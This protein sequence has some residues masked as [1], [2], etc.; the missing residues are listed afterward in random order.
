MNRRGPTFRPHA[1][2]AFAMSIFYNILGQIANLDRKPPV[3]LFFVF[4]NAAIFFLPYI[5]LLIVIPRE[6]EYI[7]DALVRLTAVHKACLIPA[8][9]VFQR[10]I[11]RIF[12]S[13]LVHGGSLHLVYNLSSFLYKGV[14]LEIELGSTQ[15]FIIIVY[16]MFSSSALYILMAVIADVMN[17]DTSIMNNCCVGFSGV[18]F[19]LKVLVNSDDIYARHT[20]DIFGF[21]MPKRTVW[22][23]LILA[24]LAGPQVSFLGHL[25]GILA[26]IIYLYIAR[27]AGFVTQT[28]RRRR[29][30]RVF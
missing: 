10:D 30:E 8:L 17:I 2:D 15:L 24:S 23:E 4:L 9:I 28:R 29:Y 21:S 6:F 22:A 5:H 16:L 25:C 19:G 3:T 14:V 12:L 27:K 1:E 7:Y 11:Y 20:E 18:I 26:G 13:T